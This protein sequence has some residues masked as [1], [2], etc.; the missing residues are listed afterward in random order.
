MPKYLK[1][2]LRWPPSSSKACC[3]QPSKAT[4]DSGGKLNKSLARPLAFPYL[5]PFS[6]CCW[7][8]H[9]PAASRCPPRAVPGRGCPCLPGQK[10]SGEPP[11][12]FVKGLTA[13]TAAGQPQGEA[14]TAP[15]EQPRGTGCE[16]TAQPRHRHRPAAAPAPTTATAGAASPQP[17]RHHRAHAAP[18]SAATAAPRTPLAAQRG[19]PPQP[20]EPRPRAPLLPAV[21]RPGC[22][23]LAAQRH[24]PERRRGGAGGRGQSGAA[25]G[26]PVGAER[27]GEERP[28][29]RSGRPGGGGQGAA[30]GAPPARGDRGVAGGRWAPRAGGAILS[31]R[32]GKWRSP[33]RQG[34]R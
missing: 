27:S 15:G 7:S 1:K 16:H 23:D 30:E 5:P 26:P 12:A 13:H 2:C 17:A 29:G 3:Y 19:A 21:P 28:L 18:T 31:G 6:L 4:R 9:C 14:N 32:A 8:H 20:P 34:G 22:T 33:D 11:S 24:L 10:L 25:P